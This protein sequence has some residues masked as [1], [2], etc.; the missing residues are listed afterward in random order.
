MTWHLQPRKLEELVPRGN[1]MDGTEHACIVM[2]Q[3]R[4]ASEGA[5]LF[6]GAA[7]LDA[8]LSLLCMRHRRD[9]HSDHLLDLRFG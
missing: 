1:C 4:L 9:G 2:L 8:A 3:W 5:L 6:I 7:G